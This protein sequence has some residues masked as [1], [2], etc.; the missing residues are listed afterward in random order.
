MFRYCGARIVVW[1]FLAGRNLFTFRVLLWWLRSR[2]RFLVGRKSPLLMYRTPYMLVII[3][4]YTSSHVYPTSNIWNLLFGYF[5]FFLCVVRSFWF[6]DLLWASCTLSRR[7][8]YGM[9][10]PDWVCVEL[11]CCFMWWWWKCTPDGCSSSGNSC[12]FPSLFVAS[13]CILDVIV[14]FPPSVNS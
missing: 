6:Y 10:W 2:N 9:M 3:C 5:I 8:F 14:L 4:E 1:P 13:R 7:L 12:R 11:G